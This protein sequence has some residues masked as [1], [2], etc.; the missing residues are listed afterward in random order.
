MPVIAVYIRFMEVA[1]HTLAEATRSAPY[2]DYAV[3]IDA[4]NRPV[5][6]KGDWPIKGRVYAVRVVESRT[7]GI[8]LIHVLTFRGEVPYFNAFAPHRFEILQR[9]WLN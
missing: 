3:C 1:S 8:P 4:D 5:N 9:L 6:H 2:L 7:E